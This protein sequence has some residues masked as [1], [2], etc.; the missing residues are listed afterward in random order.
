V[1]TICFELYC[2]VF[3]IAR[4]SSIWMLDRP[5]GELLRGDVSVRDKVCS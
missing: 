2:T 4:A 1:K 5:K 3:A